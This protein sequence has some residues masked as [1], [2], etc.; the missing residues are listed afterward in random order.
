MQINDTLKPT[1]VALLYQA[2]HRWLSGW[3]RSRV[4]CSE[5]AADLAQDT[6]VRLLRARQLSPLKEPRA[7]LSS[8]ARG[9]MIDQF[10]RRALERAYQESLAHLP[11]AE[12]P[13]E[14]DRLVILDTLARLDR[15]LH[16]LKPRARQAFLLAQLD[17]LSIVQIALRLGVSRAT[18]ERD[19]AKALGVCYRLRYA[20]A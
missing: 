8:I 19:L 20:D 9:L 13:S 12:V 10:R 14:E 6:F 1:E 4:G 18:V 17:G 3:L 5:H 7:Y 16:Q 2:H 11:E 15:A